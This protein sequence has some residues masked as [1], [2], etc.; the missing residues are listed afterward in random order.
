MYVPTAIAGA[1]VRRAD[2]GAYRT[3]ADQTAD[4]TAGDAAMS[5]PRSNAAWVKRARHA[6]QAIERRRPVARRQRSCSKSTPD[7]EWRAI[8]E[9]HRSASL[10]STVFI[11]VW[12]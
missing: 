12:T 11:S 2:G 6:A 8:R 4:A 7:P 9:G 1:V 10:R 5:A 3:D